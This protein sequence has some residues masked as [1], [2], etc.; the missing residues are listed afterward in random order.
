LKLFAFLWSEDD[1]QSRASG[2]HVPASQIQIKEASY[3]CMSFI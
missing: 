1:W 3:L 2:A